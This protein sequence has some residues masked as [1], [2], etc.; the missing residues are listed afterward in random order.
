MVFQE[1][2]IMLEGKNLIG[3]P[4]VCADGS[5][6]FDC[7]KGIVLDSS[8]THVTSLLVEQDDAGR[9]ARVLPLRDIQSFRDTD[10]MVYSPSSI[11][12]VNLV[13]N[14]RV[15]LNEQGPAMETKLVDN[16]GVAVGTVNNVVFDE[17]TGEIDSFE[18]AKRTW[19]DVL[20]GH[21]E[22]PLHEELEQGLIRHTAEVKAVKHGDVIAAPIYGPRTRAQNTFD[23]ER[24]S[25]DGMPGE[26]L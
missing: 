9:H 8:E 7:V 25:D 22:F 5:E 4:V 13:P 16:D 2:Q 21:D 14:I 1:I 18:V 15:I 6:E 20:F 12:E 10:I 24:A 17:Q 23:R 26:R 3:V 11:H 19:T